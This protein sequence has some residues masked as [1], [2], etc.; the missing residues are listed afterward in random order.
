MLHHSPTFA[1]VQQHVGC[2]NFCRRLQGQPFLAACAALTVND[3]NAA[4]NSLH[5]GNEPEQ[6]AMMC[7]AMAQLGHVGPVL[8]DRVFHRVSVKCES[9]EDWESAAAALNML[10][11]D[12]EQQVQLL[13]VRAQ[14]GSR[15]AAVDKLRRQLGLKEAGEYEKMAE[16]MP[17]PIDSVR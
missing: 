4:V 10:S 15:G 14:R 5:L 3:V 12:A 7:L 6:A 11:Q 8:Q 9:A 2:L 17:E 1:F 13:M 16:L